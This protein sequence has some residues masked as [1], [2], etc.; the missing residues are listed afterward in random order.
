MS[1]TGS[2]VGRLFAV[3]T[4]IRKEVLAVAPFSSL[5]VKVIFAL[6]TPPGEGTITM[7]LLLP[8]PPKMIASFGT[9]TGFE[10]MPDTTRLSGEVSRSATTNGISAAGKPS[11]VD[12]LGMLEITGTSLTPVTVRRNDL[13]LVVEPS[14]AV[15]VIVAVPF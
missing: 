5:A 13:L 2:M 9:R 6:P 14:L 7:V 12:C 4:A 3:V 15:T 10:E 8:A 1:P 11:L